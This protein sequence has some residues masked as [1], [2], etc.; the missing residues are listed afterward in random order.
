MAVLTYTSARV[1]R[2]EMCISE[3]IYPTNS[4]TPG[5]NEANNMAKLALYRLLD[6][7]H[8]RNPNVDM[9]LYVDDMRQFASG[10][11]T[12]EVAQIACPAVTS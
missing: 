4:I 11:E 2:S 3:P 1:V 7:M 12:S 6:W 9:G 8:V 10:K 5:C